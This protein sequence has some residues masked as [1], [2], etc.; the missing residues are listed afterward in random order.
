MHWNTILFR[1]ELRPLSVPTGKSNPLNH[2]KSIHF[3][4]VHFLLFAP[5]NARAHEKT[6]F[7]SYYA[8]VIFERLIHFIKGHFSLSDF[9][10]VQVC[11]QGYG[12]RFTRKRRATIPILV[13]IPLNFALC[14]HPTHEIH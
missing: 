14:T 9:S 1:V 4:H 7:L 6:L 5:V 8:T 13:I 12:P 11:D 3:G 2:I 10:C